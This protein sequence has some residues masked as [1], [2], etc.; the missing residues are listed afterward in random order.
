MRAIGSRRR[1]GALLAVLGA[2]LA[3]PLAALARC[4]APAAQPH[5]CH[6]PVKMACCEAGLCHEG[7]DPDPASGPAWSSCRDEVPGHAAVPAPSTALD[8][9][10]LM[11]SAPG[12]ESTGS[13]IVIVE[14]A[15]A[16]TTS[17]VPATPPPRRSIVPC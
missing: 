3:L 16:T 2:T 1:A 6:C 7:T 15:A 11:A 17:H 9:A 5:G 13:R 14:P 8:W 12:V 4:S 10:L